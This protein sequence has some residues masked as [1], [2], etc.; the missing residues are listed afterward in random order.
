[1]R[2]MQF[3]DYSGTE[4]FR[5]LS[6]WG[7]FGYSILFAI[8]IIGWIF[9]LVFTFSTKNYNRRSFARSYWCGFLVVAIIIGILLAT[10]V[11]AGWLYEKIPVLREWIPEPSDRILDRVSSTAQ[12]AQNA[13]DA[14]TGEEKL[15]SVVGVTQV[16]TS[17]TDGV[18]PEFKKTMDEYEAFFDSYIE[19]MES[20]DSGSATIAQLAKYAE[21]M[22]QYTETMEALDQIEE[23]TMTEA[24]DQYYTEVMLRINQKLASFAA[25]Q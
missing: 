15:T 14:V 24:D 12:P 7:Y 6:A 1:M 17:S 10:G 13:G 22:T 21:M 9:L 4:Q 11:G 8:P 3:K 18:T 2:V 16:P 23:S 20:Y 19:F 25:A 5:P